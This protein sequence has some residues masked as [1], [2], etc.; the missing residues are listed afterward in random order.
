MFAVLAIGI[1]LAM[2]FAVIAYRRGVETLGVSMGAI[3]V[4]VFGMLIVGI[5]AAML[6]NDYFVEQEWYL[7]QTGQLVLFDGEYVE[8]EGDETVFFMSKDEKGELSY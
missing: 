8:H 3:C 5:P 4:F 2:I 6:L 1:I 7:Y